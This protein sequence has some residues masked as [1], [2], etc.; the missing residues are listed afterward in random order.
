MKP[1]KVVIVDDHPVFIQGLSLVIAGDPAFAVAGHASG[2]TAALTLIGN[3]LPDLAIVDLNLGEEDGLALIQTIHTRFPDVG[4]LALSMLSE[5]FYAERSLSAGARGY[6]MKDESPAVILQAMGEVSAG[7]TWLS[8]E[9]HRRRTEAREAEGGNPSI[10]QTADPLKLLSARQIQVLELLG[11]GFGTIE[12]SARL[13]I[14]R[15]TVET[16]KDQI[17]KTLHCASVQELV[18]LAVDWTARNGR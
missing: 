12:I 11:K 2:G 14:S 3:E 10:E 5:R 9:E 17:K 13:A 4:V 7:K 15:K 6:V 18:Q 1:V 16:H 8:R